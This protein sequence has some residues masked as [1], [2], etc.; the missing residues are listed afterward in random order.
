MRIFV[1]LI[2]VKL[3]YQTNY[4]CDLIFS[5][6]ENSKTRMTENYVASARISESEKSAGRNKYVQ[7]IGICRIAAETSM[8]NLS[9]SERSFGQ[10]QVSSVAQQ[11]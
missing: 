2:R 1:M 10:K 6:S 8:F 4:L 5:K 7:F 9:E 3:A 11:S